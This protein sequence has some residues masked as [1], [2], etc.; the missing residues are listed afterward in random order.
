MIML[1]MAQ[2]NVRYVMAPTFVK[3][4]KGKNIFKIVKL[5]PTLT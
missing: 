3:N 4:V 2:V 1:T 5:H